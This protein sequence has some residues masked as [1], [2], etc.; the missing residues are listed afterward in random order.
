MESNVRIIKLSAIRPGLGNT[1]E[2]VC[3]SRY[4]ESPETDS[5]IAPN[6]CNYD[7]AVT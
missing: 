3:I 7:D 2:K 4:F 6:V 1:I 5:Q